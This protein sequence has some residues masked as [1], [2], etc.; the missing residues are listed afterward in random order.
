[1]INRKKKIVFFFHYAWACVYVYAFAMEGMRKWVKDGDWKR[2]DKRL[3]SYCVWQQDEVTRSTL[4][5]QQSV[6]HRT[7]SLATVTSSGFSTIGCRIERC[8]LVEYNS[9]DVLT[10]TKR[11]AVVICLAVSLPHLPIVWLTTVD[12]GRIL[13]C[14]LLLSSMN[15]DIWLSTV[16]FLFSVFIFT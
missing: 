3:R 14:L 12:L 15:N 5:A 4:F 2:C 6:N 11:P 8:C 9:Y 1:M 13:T 16:F 7:I 10:L